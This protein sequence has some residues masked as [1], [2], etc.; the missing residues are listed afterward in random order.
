MPQL[1][2]SAAQLSEAGAKPANEDSVGIR[3]PDEPALLDAKGVALVIADGMSGSEA[4]REA[5]DACVQGF[6]NDYFST[7]DS[8]TVETSGE[9]ILGALNRWLYSQGHQAYGT[10][11]GL[12]TT[13]S[14]LVIKSTTAYIFHVGD[15][16]IYRLR[17]GEL[18]QLTQDHRVTVGAD[19]S[20]LSRAMGIDIN[21]DIDYRS[22][23]VERGDAY[24]L[25]TDGI[26]DFV[27]DT[28]LKRLVI[29]NLAT[30]EQA[31][32]TILRRAA[33][34][35]SNDNLSAQLI[36]IED[37]PQ[38]DENEFFRK[39]T[40]LP[41]PPPLEPGMVL[42]GYR[43]LRELHASN[44][45][46][47]YLALDTETDTEIVLKT[48]SVN[49]EDDP[50][51]I[52]QFLHE[53][54]VGKRLN[55]PHVL[56]VL[57][58]HGRRQCLYYVTEY[59]QGQT[60]RQWMHDHPQPA[61]GE[62]RSII[63]QITRG[64]R[65]MHRQEM[66]HQDIKPE[67]LM[68][69]GH[70]V[71]KIIDF[72]STKIAGIA[73]ITTPLQRDNILGTRNYTAPEY[74]KGHPGSNRSDIYSLGV[75]AYEMLCGKLPYPKELNERNLRRV[76]YTSIRRHRPDIPAWVDGALMKA[77]A[78]NPERRHGLLSEFVYDLSHPNPGYAGREQPPLIERDPVAFWRALAL[79]FLATT[80]AAL[81]F[82]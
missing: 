26:H 59:I 6:L 42:D 78:I 45:T 21:L 20:Y 2:V 70:G 28:T 27:D 12:V 53:E 54:W 50:E 56:K 74:L 32:R 75:L 58:P 55:S 39:L 47:V 23:G 31:V 43:I 72:G 44:R 15:T 35:D 25:T 40:R 82:R 9:K 67:N 13:L 71:V 76:E 14:V 5:A 38:G 69:D 7:P 22:F 10:P 1:T 62:V 81:F 3:I 29:E 16:R 68:I 48:P 11:K 30:P 36:C 63:E 46:Q 51:Y 61:L 65:A 8:W 66:I 80:L 34:N 19:K 79:I 60:L 77:V 18:E 37:L 4:G 49:F 33:G 24:L 73:E 17:D 57:E 64:L 41:F 52:D